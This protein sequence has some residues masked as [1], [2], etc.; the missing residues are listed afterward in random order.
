MP[1]NSNKTVDG[2]LEVPT[3]EINP[4]IGSE[5]AQ[6]RKT[7]SQPLLKQNESPSSEMDLIN[8]KNKFILQEMMEPIDEFDIN[9][10]KL[11]KCKQ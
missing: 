10:L 3:S 8:E 1:S 9:N 2:L 7:H 6:H 11:N 4:K 5:K